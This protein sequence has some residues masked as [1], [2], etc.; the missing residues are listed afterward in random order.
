MRAR[1][2]VGVTRRCSTGPTRSGLIE[3]SIESSSSCC[4]AAFSLGASCSSFSGSTVIVSVSTV[5]RGGDRGGDDA[6]LGLQALRS[7]GDDVG[8]EL[9]EQQEADD[10]DQQAAEIERDDAARQ[11]GGK[12]GERRA[13]EDAQP[14]ARARPPPARARGGQE[15]FAVGFA[16]HRCARRRSRRAS[17]LSGVTL[18]GSGSRRRRASRSFRIP[19][20]R[21]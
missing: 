18:P 9:V 1:V 11:R 2:R 4:G 19:A 21:P 14:Q 3:N 10:Q 7:R 6:G 16:A 13:P 12:A 20:R 5:G 17:V 15:R 8:A